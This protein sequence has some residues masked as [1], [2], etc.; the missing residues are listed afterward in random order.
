MEILGLGACL[1]WAPL[2]D[3]AKTGRVTDT[4]SRLGINTPAVYTLDEAIQTIRFFRGEDDVPA[5]LR[6]LCALPPGAPS[7]GTGRELAMSPQLILVEINSPVRV[8]YG[9]HCLN[10]A[11]VQNHILAPLAKK[12][13]GLPADW[14]YRGLMNGNRQFQLDC[15]EKLIAVVKEIDDLPNPELSRSVLREAVPLRRDLDEIIVCLEQLAT[16]LPAPM[17]I[18]TYT[19]EYMP[20]GRPLPWPPDFVELQIS[21]AER[22]GLPTFRPSELVQSR[23]IDGAMREDR[24]H[25]Q[26]GF[27]PLLADEL[28]QFVEKVHT[29]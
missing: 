28:W 10:R 26:D 15:A 21:A 17:A 19:H 16:L 24:V 23:G 25:Y 20:D 8:C 5:E 22:L 4:W 6:A 29:S 1:L 13:P 12:A 3:L 14:Y 2:C 9:R 18:V 11:A 27:V 7:P